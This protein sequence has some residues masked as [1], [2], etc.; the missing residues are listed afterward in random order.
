MKNIL[1]VFLLLSTALFAQQNDKKWDKV[2]AYENEGKIKSANEIVEKIYKKAV[3]DK[4]EVQMI[5]SFFYQSKYL[6]VVDENAQTKILNNLKTDINRVSIPSKAILNLIYAKC[7]SDYF[8]RNDYKIRNRTNTAILNEDFLTWPE[9]NF[10]NEINLALKNSLEN[11]PILKNTPLIKYE[12]IFDYAT[13]E[14]FKTQ[15]LLDYVIS[16]NIT[17][18][19]QKIHQWEIQKSDFL[20]H[21]KEL[22]QN[23]NVF[24]KLNFDFITNENLKL[25]LKLY[26]KQEENNP[27]V[28]NLWDRIQFCKKYIIDVDENYFQALISLQKNT[29]GALLI[30]RIQLE[31]ASYLN[32]NVSKEIHPDYN[33]KAIAILD[34]ILNV[35][36][37]SNAYKL[38]IQ[39][40]ENILYKSLTTQLQKYNYN[41][42]NI[43]AFIQ[44]KNVENLKITFFKIAQNQLSE[45]ERYSSKRDSVKS[46]IIE[47]TQPLVTKSYTLTNKKDYLEYSTEVLLPQLKT[48]SYLVYF[49]S[50]SDSKDKKASAYETI[51]ISNFIVLASQ[52]DKSENYQVLDRKTGK[53]LENVTLKSPTFTITTNKNGVA[54]FQKE[55]NISYE[56]VTLSTTN[57]TLTV[58]KNYLYYNNPYSAADTENFK[59][60]VEF[61][62]DRAIYRPGQ[63]VYY[64]GIAIQKLRNKTSVVSKTTFKIVIEDA[65]GIEIK[66]F[67]A[68]TNEFGSFSGEFV[69]P[70][71]GL[72]GNFTITAD[73]PDDYEN[74]IVY[75]K[76]ED[77][78]P[79]WSKVDFEDSQIEF[80]VEEYKRPKFEVTFDPKKESFQI[81]QSIKVKGSAK[82]FAGSNISDAIVTYT[83]TRYISYYRNYYSQEQNEVLATGETKTDASGKFI[84]DFVALPSKNSKKEQLP[85][86]NYIINV[87]VTD[88]NGE[89]H[90]SQTTVKVGYH[91]LELKTLIGNEIE[92]KDKNEIKLISTNLNGEFLAAK[93]ELKIYY[94]SPFSTKFKGRVFPQ[95]DFETIS[96]QDFEKLF[97]YENNQNP[98]EKATETLVFSKNIDTQKDK[99]LALDFI[100]NYKSGNYKIVFSSKDSFDNLIE[101]TSDFKLTQSKDKFDTSR[102]FKTH[103]I[104]TDAKKDGFALIKITSIIP[105]LYITTTGNYDN[106]VFS[107][108]IYHL[109]NN[110]IVIKI[111]LKKEFKDAVLISFESIFENEKFNNNLYVF[112]KTENPQLK[113]NLETFRNKI[114]PG[115]A[116]NWSFKLNGIG[117][118]NEAEVL[119]SMYDNSL[120]QFSTK[121]WNSLSIN[122]YFSSGSNNK[123]LLGSDKTFTSILNLNTPS[124]RIDL[125]NETTK[126]IRFGFDFNGNNNTVY[127][128]REYQRQLNKKIKKP[129]NAKM[130]SGIVTDNSGLPLPGVSILIKGTERGTQSDF[131]GYY[132]IE[133]TAN[134]EL[135]FSYIGF[136]S[137]SAFVTNKKTIDLS[138]TEDSNHLE[139]VMITTGYGM[140]KVKKSLSY[141][142]TK[143]SS[144]SVQVE[145]DNNVY[146]TA[147]IANTLAGIVPGIQ[148]RGTA[149]PNGESP[150]YI[151]DGEIVSDIKSIN[152]TE[153]LSID[154]LKDEKAT[155]LYGSRGKNG[156]IIITTKKALEALTQVKAR[157]NLSETA[158]FLPNLRT[159]SNGKV[160][161]NF[162]SPEA[163]T[164]WK[165]RL[166]AHNKDAVS[167]YLEKSVLTQKELMV[168]PNFPRFFRE[169]DTIVISAKI[170]NITD[171]VKTG[172]AILQLFDAITM[173]PIDAKILNAKN[174]R[175]F[176]VG[177]FG[178]TTAS[179]TI[180]IPDGLQGVQYKILAKSGNFSDGEENI[181]P[182]LTNNMLVTESIPIWVRE[183]STKEYT[184]ENLKNNTS[185]TLKNHQFTLE[186]TSNPSWIAIQS[187][188]YLMEYEHE[189]AEQTFARFYSN[190]LASEIISSN[191]KIATVFEN[192]RKNGKLN[193]K[194]EENEELKSLVLAETPWLNDAQSEDEKKKNLALLFDLEKMKT[195]QEATFDKLKQKQKSSGGFAWF[196]GGNESEYITRH[197]LAGLGHL[198]KLNKTQENDA[199]FDA[200]AKTGIP[201]LDKSFLESYK[202]RTKN[203]K[204]NDKLI[205][206][207][208]YSD[209]HYLYTRSFYLDK[210]QLSD[211]L[212]KASKLY[213]ETAK[214]DWLS[215]SIYEKGLAALT[216]NRFG[217]SETAKKIIENL[218]ET[219]S[220]NEDWGMYW[221]ANKAGWYWYQA[222]IETQALLIE[223]FAEVNHDIK[224]VDAMKVWLL[225]NKQT[226]NWPTTKSTTEAV[227]ALLM[228]GNDWLSVKDNTIIKIGDEKILTKKL[229]ENEKEA[230]TGYIKLNWKADEVKKEMA[231]ISIQNKSKVPGFGGIYW[232]YFENLD[233]IKTNSGAV[234]SV[235][236]ELYL[237]KNTLKGN[238]L[239]KTT[240]KNALK[241]GDLV[242]VRLIITAKEDMEYVHLKDMRASC[243]EPINVL[244]EY[245]YKDGL[246]YY[247]ST[248]DAATHLFF[249]YIN[250]GTYVIEYDIRVNNSGEFSNGITTIESMYAPEFSSHT[251]GIRIKVN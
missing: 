218:K 153:I 67:D 26:Q 18:Y 224:S 16:E 236:K 207:N 30:Q 176:T 38:A 83:V 41:E 138:L 21:K 238:E 244:S 23:S 147:G 61:Y 249:D 81:N 50:E 80:R 219:A 164:A 155:A 142:V 64:K 168:L 90:E 228:Q 28:E 134:E 35:N 87:A 34:S 146:N 29:T 96:S 119:A 199:K 210:Y 237:K 204:T 222:P 190:A 227:Y 45:L 65:N 192:W 239:E 42:E 135:L 25:T 202:I 184:F 144:E 215:Y 179:W 186:Y 208:P 250:K 130:I 200:I 77:R 129:L 39:K 113:F 162:T 246:G 230:E 99:T 111:P 197:I 118:K 169:K 59:G 139:A 15:S 103:Q 95:P 11:E 141:A 185:T 116:E 193:S 71:T 68:T 226:K 149:S 234:L 194:L 233:K 101:T 247:M 36:N 163:L 107:E 174:V 172:I 22:L 57:D 123:S 20:L 108:D 86:F 89:T 14:K 40:K 156:V 44:Y 112:L 187:L 24:L 72:T 150:L 167:G 54:Y 133:A 240:S 82:A 60:K 70:K 217:E 97:P 152:P 104:N 49:E 75:N 151:V 76:T 8:T 158:F 220:N 241:T 251:K 170:S 126:L 55:K 209:L 160:S 175:N 84:I 124:N 223:A 114:Q 7:L 37:R 3:S 6:Q 182:V 157:K 9:S 106:K 51:T 122:E 1:F 211:T 79:F 205:W 10:T 94:V 198:S 128:Q 245:Q 117:T 148:I 85:V 43:R 212:K 161:F 206:I 12:P 109:Q 166:L 214:K 19:T 196:D 27:T 52:N 93:G 213:L 229:T 91:D 188:P 92:T 33:I 120:D 221:I 31:K 78:H 232:Q 201:F 125:K 53:P 137:Y 105:E 46:F 203:L 63:T 242:T 183:N 189:C 136:K 100:T 131:D 145:E 216:L 140:K 74:D 121:D 243:F 73:E 69:L 115:S 66:K 56:V 195:S 177:A 248:K 110:E 2:I 98:K 88:I 48:G 5:K 171:K 178:N 235:L 143:I 4:D 127:L 231:S 180:S 17:L 159:D 225:K 13:V 181:L 154:V 58:Q 32:D 47:K 132:E 62:L 191:P 102:L 173:Q 165:L